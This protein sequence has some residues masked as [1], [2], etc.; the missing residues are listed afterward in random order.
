PT[1]QET[2][3]A[4]II[5]AEA[6]D[7]IDTLADGI[8]KPEDVVIIQFGTEMS[9]DALKSSIYQVNGKSLPEG[10]NITSTEATY[11]ASGLKG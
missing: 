5:W 1:E 7:N 6:I 3:K 10:V 11:T 4:Q 8:I 9:I 2:G